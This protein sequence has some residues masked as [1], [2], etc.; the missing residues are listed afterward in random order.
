MPKPIIGITW[1]SQPHYLRTLQSTLFREA[2]YLAIQQAGGIPHKLESHSTKVDS[3]HL[4]GILFSGGGDINPLIYGVTDNEYAQGIDDERD[5]LELDLLRLALDNHI[6]FLG[7]CRG[8]QLINV[9]LGGSLYQDLSILRSSGIPHDWHPSRKYLAHSISVDYKSLLGQFGFESN[10][11]VNSLHH[12]GI[13]AIGKNLTPI[14]HASDGLIEA[15]QV[16]GHPF[17]LAVQWHPEWLNDQQSTR[18]LFESFIHACEH[19]L[20]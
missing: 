9:G 17:G 6:P 16:T 4:D 3:T 15:I 1:S 14:A 10:H 19:T 13:R 18:C 11:F 5:R 7:I 8:L 12:Q 2:Y 20:Q